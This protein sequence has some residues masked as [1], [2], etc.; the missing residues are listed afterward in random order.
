MIFA[1][2]DI[3]SNALRL[4]F[5]NIFENEKGNLSSLRT[6]F[7]RVPIRL[8]GDVFACGQISPEREQKLIKS[9]AA[10]KALIEVN[11]AIDYEAVATSAMREAANGQQI[12]ER[13]EKELGIRIR[14]IDGQE[15][16]KIIRAAGEISADPSFPV[17]MMI[18]VGGGSTEISVMKNNHFVNSQS[19]NIGTLRLLNK[20]VD[21]GEW[22][23]MHDWLLLFKPYFGQ[24]QCIGSGGNINKITKQFGDR[25]EKII[26]F[27]QLKQAYSCLSPISVEKRMEIYNFR[28]DRADVIVP[29][30]EIYINILQTI[31]ASHILAPKIGL[32]DG[33]VLDLYRKHKPTPSTIQI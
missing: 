2:I 29:A 10:F 15:E 6:A 11:E 23:R 28:A 22:N 21:P 18:D 3:G 5:T 31:K 16:A 30:I 9:L 12:I 32:A 27:K 1:S 13:I 8:G 25:N 17:T 7:I 26:S 14:I 4:L 33:L 20:N 19:F 24:I